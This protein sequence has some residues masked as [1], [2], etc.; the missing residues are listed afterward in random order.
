[1]AAQQQKRQKMAEEQEEIEEVQHGPFPIEQ[2]QVNI[3]QRRFLVET[4]INPDLRSWRF[5]FSCHRK[6]G[7]SLTPINGAIAHLFSHETSDFPFQI[8]LSRSSGNG[9]F[10]YCF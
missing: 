1:M 4:L 10:A 9:C 7:A 5:E 8:M 3:E 6:R 2:L